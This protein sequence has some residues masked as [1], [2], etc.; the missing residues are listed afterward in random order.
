MAVL[1][2]RTGNAAATSTWSRCRDVWWTM[3]ASVAVRHRDA[4]SAADTL[5]GGA[6][7]DPA[8]PQ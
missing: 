7:G 3:R 1:N 2:H 4:A 6:A 5:S 8:L